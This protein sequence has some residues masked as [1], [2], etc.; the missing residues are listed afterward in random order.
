MDARRF[1]KNY[2]AEKLTH[3]YL[4]TIL[5]R[6]TSTI[7]GPWT[8]TNE[9]W[10]Y[11]IKDKSNS[12]MTSI[13]RHNCNGM[14]SIWRHTLHD[15]K[16]NTKVKETWQKNVIRSKIDNVHKQVTKKVCV[17]TYLLTCLLAWVL[18]LCEKDL[19]CWHLTCMWW[20]P[21]VKGM[22]LVKWLRQDYGY[23]QNMPV[24]VTMIL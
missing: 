4:Q 24:T 19:K 1:A 12:T 22:K 10:H 21:A 16:L 3:K 17:S 9:W 2:C 5:N 11:T 7:T 13:W 20:Y 18:T 23:D 14:F 6:I 8:A 15:V